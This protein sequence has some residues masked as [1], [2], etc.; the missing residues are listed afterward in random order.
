M[1]KKSMKNLFTR[2]IRKEHYDT[3]ILKSIERSQMK[4]FDHIM[5]RNVLQNL[6][7]TVKIQGKRD[8]GTPRQTHMGSL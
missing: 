1:N 3:I 6:R 4:F 2:Q 5:R 8:R 7:L